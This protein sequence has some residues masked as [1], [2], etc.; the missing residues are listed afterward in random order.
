[1]ASSGAK[2]KGRKAGTRVR[3]LSVKTVSS[4]KGK[5]VRGGASTLPRGIQVAPSQSKVIVSG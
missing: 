5:N 3:S 1:M 4:T 2:T